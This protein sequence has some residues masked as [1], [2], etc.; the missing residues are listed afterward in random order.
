MM[1]SPLIL[2]LS[3][4]IL[5]AAC[6]FGDDP[7]DGFHPDPLTAGL[8][9]LLCL[10]AIT[11]SV[12][13]IWT[14][15]ALLTSRG[16]RAPYVFLL[17]TLVFF[18]WSNAA[19]IALIILGNIPSLSFSDTFPVLLIPTLGF[20]SNLLNDWAVVLQ[21]LAIIAVIWNRENTLRVAT[22]GK[23]GGHHP[24]L[25]A[26]HVALAALTLAFGTAA[27]AYNMD[28]NVQY[29]TTEEL[30]FGDALHHRIVVYQQLFYVFSSFAVL[31]AVDVV[32][33]TVLLW[34]GWKNAGIPDKITNVVLY[35]LVP[36][37]CALSLVIMIFTIIF[38][39]SGLP[40]TV[41]VTVVESAGLANTLLATGFSI[42]VIIII[43]ALS[44][45]KANWNIGGVEEPRQQYWV[46]QP[47]YTYAAPPQPQP[48][49]YG[50]APQ[51]PQPM[52]YAPTEEA[53]P[54]SYADVRPGGSIPASPPSV[55]TSP[56]Y[57]PAASPPPMHTSPGYTAPSSLLMHAS[58][59][60]YSPPQ[61]SQGQ[62]STPYP[63]DKSPGYSTPPPMH[64]SPGYTTPSSPP[65]HAT[66]SYSPPQS[67]QGQSSTPYPPEKGG[68]H[69]TYV[70]PTS[71]I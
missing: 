2:V 26:L 59:G 46:P 41:T 42:T 1:F 45:K 27:E 31:T 11:Y 51:G 8:F 23:F 54:G 13:I 57:T 5:P 28:T 25:I 9:G 15:V 53:R 68:L 4:L 66:G 55:H 30:F 61:S 20:I 63:P 22:E 62:P 24:A 70:P 52:Q 56:G 49:Y 67:S 34:R 29:Y 69:L 71:Q 14:F 32:V 3:S 48:G 36:V 40:P 64:T 19:F 6:Q 65:M 12:L 10:F 33:S 18:A 47:Q 21:F 37:Y 60:S 50:G 44:I 17:P 16:H 58:P 38:S 39:P 43:L 7:P 35:A